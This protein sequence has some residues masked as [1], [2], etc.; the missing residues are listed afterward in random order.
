MSSENLPAIWH[1]L[2]KIELAIS[3]LQ[4]RTA[5]IHSVN[6]FLLTH[7]NGYGCNHVTFGLKFN[8]FCQ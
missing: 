7:G 4:E 5:A 8:P 6:D 3:R 2:N 1:T